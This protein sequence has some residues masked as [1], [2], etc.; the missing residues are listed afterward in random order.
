MIVGLFLIARIM[1]LK[2]NW[3]VLDKFVEDGIIL[4]FYPCITLDYFVPF[5]VSVWCV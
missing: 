4:I 2:T 3:F 1:L 5:I